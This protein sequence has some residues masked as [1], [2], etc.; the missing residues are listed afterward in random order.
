MSSVVL[1]EWELAKFNE[2]T[3][4]KRGAAKRSTFRTSPDN[5][6][7]GNHNLPGGMPQIAYLRRRMSVVTLL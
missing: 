5:Y 4:D 1:I 2:S 3:F 7:I 6:P